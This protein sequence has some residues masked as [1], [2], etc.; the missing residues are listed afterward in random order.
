MIVHLVLFKLKPG[1]AANDPR[2]ASLVAEMNE[3]PKRIPLIKG[4]EHGP[5]LISDAKAWSYG[6][7][8]LFETEAD[9]Y[10][11]FGHPAHVPVVEHWNE[12]A[13]LA[14]VDFKS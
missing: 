13:M 6:L 9:L 12:I 8:A 10:A 1:V 3:L 7:R 2:L 11:Y 4:W 5:N 14:F